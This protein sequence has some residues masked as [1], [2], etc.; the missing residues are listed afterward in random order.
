[1]ENNCEEGDTYQLNDSKKIPPEEHSYTEFVLHRR[2]SLKARDYSW[3]FSLNEF[4]LWSLFNTC[5]NSSV[6]LWVT[7]CIIMLCNNYLSWIRYLKVKIKLQLMLKTND[8]IHLFIGKTI[9]VGPSSWYWI[10]T[11]K[12]RAQNAL[13]PGTWTFTS[14]W[15]RPIGNGA[16]AVGQGFMIISARNM[17]RATSV[18]RNHILENIIYDFVQSKFER[19]V[20]TIYIINA[21]SKELKGCTGTSLSSSPSKELVY[22]LC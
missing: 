4:L 19:N 10:L 6:M 2:S 18:W 13:I 8:P 7:S 9:K 12:K 14:A 22:H 17:Q 11:Q 1:M 20:Y 5:C 16:A 3:L 15:Q 21:G